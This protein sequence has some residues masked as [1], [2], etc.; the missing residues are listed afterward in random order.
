MFFPPETDGA[1]DEPTS[2]DVDTAEDREAREDA[3]AQA[4]ANELPSAPTGELSGSGHVDKKQKQN[5]D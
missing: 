5:D 4:V 3:E 1:M 2:S